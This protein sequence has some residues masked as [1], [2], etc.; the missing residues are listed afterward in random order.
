ML[1]GRSGADFVA[2]AA[3]HDPD[4]IVEFGDDTRFVS[5]NLER[6]SDFSLLPL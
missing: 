1:W 5:E 6:I 4:P 3:F 2:S